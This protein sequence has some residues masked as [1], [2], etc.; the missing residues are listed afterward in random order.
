MATEHLATLRQSIPRL[1]QLISHIEPTFRFD[2]VADIDASFIT[3][4][5][6]RVVL[7]D[8]DGTLMAY[9]AG[10]VDARFPLIRVLF[11]DGPARHAILSNCDERRF[12]QLGQIFPEIPLLRGYATDEGP[13]FRHL[14]HGTD[15]HTSEALRHIQSN[16]GTQIRKPSGELVRY[17]MRVLGEADPQAVLVVGDQYL[18]DIASA[19]L[20]GAR[21]AKVSTF[22]Q[23][24]FPVSIR[25]SQH[26]ENAIY[27]VFGS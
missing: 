25:L 23:D 2:T 3:E 10:D 19:N 6:F 20:A 11:R 21:S 22:R 14:W 24:T 12:D 7:W 15:T 18:T 16:R 27:R 9:H 13:V 8:V 17:G 1:R 26:L 4:Q 5:G